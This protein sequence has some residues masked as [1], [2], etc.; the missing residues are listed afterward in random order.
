M[1]LGIGHET[2]LQHISLYAYGIGILRHGVVSK[3]VHELEV[4]RCGP[5]LCERMH[6]S[7]I[8]WVG[9]GE[10]WSGVEWSGIAPR[11]RNVLGKE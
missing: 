3:V 2:S 7:S 6:G 5:S 1:E 4:R 11:P 10:E 9:R 8:A